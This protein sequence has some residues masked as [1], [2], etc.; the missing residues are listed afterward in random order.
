[1]KDDSYVHPDR[2]PGNV[3]GPFYTTGAISPD[4]TWC[5]NCLS[6]GVPEM[7]AP[8]LLSPLTDEDCDT[9][10]VR[11]P[12]TEQE[13]DQAC[14]AITSCCVDALRYGGRDPRI[15]ARLPAAYCDFPCDL[16]RVG[17]LRRLCSFLFAKPP[18]R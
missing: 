14:D 10:F 9:Y 17:Y 8:T 6:C 16:P 11:Q 18:A 2:F 3:P 7:A 1:M 13:I 5:A 4:G 12:Q 15:L